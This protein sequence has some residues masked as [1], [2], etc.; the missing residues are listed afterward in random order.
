M[1]QEE[2]QPQPQITMPSSASNRPGFY[3]DE[4][5]GSGAP[6]IGQSATQNDRG[7]AAVKDK[8]NKSLNK[9]QS[10]GWFG[11]IWG[12]FS[13]KPKNQMILPDDKNPSVIKCFNYCKAKDFQYKLLIDCLGSGQKALG[14]YRWRCG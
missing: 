13:L 1:L 2:V 11:G 7:K 10:S 12:K 14:K 6:G 5:A 4:P 3:D 9:D 8:E